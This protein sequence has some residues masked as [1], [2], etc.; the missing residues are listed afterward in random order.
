MPAP[1]RMELGK[2]R[3]SMRVCYV[4]TRRWQRRGEHAA[5]TQ[6]FSSIIQKFFRRKV[7]ARAVLFC[8]PERPGGATCAVSRLSEENSM[9]RV[10]TMS[11]RHGLG[12]LLATLVMAAGWVASPV[13]TADDSP[14]ASAA[15]AGDLAAVRTLIEK[16][17]DVNAPQAD[18]STALL[19]AAY[20]SDA[21]MT[22]ALLA[23]GARVD[24]ANRYGVTPLIQA[25][26][27][28]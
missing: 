17:A 5:K 13:F 10:R 6:R 8:A 3:T 14:V 2:R 22:R 1:G 21:D 16:R 7:V 4:G 18:G 25:S 23:A 28:G 15:K 27:T 12:V 19:W 11:R 20:N 24:A 26:R 9:K